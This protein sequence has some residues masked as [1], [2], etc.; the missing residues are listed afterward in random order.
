MC[1]PVVPLV[2]HAR[3][4][5]GERRWLVFPAVETTVTED[6]RTETVAAGGGGGLI[7]WCV[8]SPTRHPGSFRCRHHH[9]DYE[10][11]RRITKKKTGLA[12]FASR[13]KGTQGWW[14]YSTRPKK[15]LEEAHVGRTA[16]Q[17]SIINLLKEKVE[18][19]YHVEQHLSKGYK[20][21]ESVVF[22]GE[23]IMKL[24]ASNLLLECV[25]DSFLLQSPGSI[26]VFE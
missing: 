25:R 9:A 19:Q 8:C 1:N 16:G 5:V 20:K 4:L 22:G 15:S 14:V 12:G 24:G 10:W 13:G 2:S 17:N 3:T 11:S 7:K 18:R 6:A 21:K 23:K 26:W